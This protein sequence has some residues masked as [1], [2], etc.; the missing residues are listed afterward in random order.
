VIREFL[1]LREQSVF[2]IGTIKSGG[3]MGM[4]FEDCELNS[5]HYGQNST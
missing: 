1:K 3:V 2:V 4:S 5:S